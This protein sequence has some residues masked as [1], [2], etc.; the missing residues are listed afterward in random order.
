M[1]RLRNSMNVLSK[2]DFKE[3]FLRNM[4]FDIFTH[5][6]TFTRTEIQFQISMTFL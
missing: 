1:Q 6:M 2:N 4:A 3:T 5:F